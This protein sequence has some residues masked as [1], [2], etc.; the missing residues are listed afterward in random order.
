MAAP[1]IQVGDQVINLQ[2]PGLFRVIDRRG[3]LMVIETARGLR[4]TVL[5]SQL[6]RL[7]DVALAPSTTPDV[8]PDPTI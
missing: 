4:M 1:T 8:P 2:V 6:R 7:D 5:D 3:A